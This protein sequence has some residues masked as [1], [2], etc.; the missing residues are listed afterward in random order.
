MVTVVRMRPTEGLET[1]PEELSRELRDGSR[2]ALSEMYRRW[3]PLIYTMARRSLGDHHD[4]E[5]VVQQV[6][7]SAW[8]GRE[9]IRPSEQALPGW[10]VGIAKHRIADH[11]EKRSRARRN[12][13]AVAAAAPAVEHQVVDEQDHAVNRLMLA[14]ELERLGEPRASILRLAVVEDRPQEEIAQVM[15]LPLGTVKSHV[16]RGLRHLRA[17]V[18]EV[19]NAAS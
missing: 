1:S 15:G 18:E 12:L 13:S 11:H 6:F 7:V 9:G 17:Q 3:S 14:Y 2:E 4:A 10:L 5:D 19:T 8:R 16:R